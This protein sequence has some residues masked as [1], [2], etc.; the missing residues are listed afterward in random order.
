MGMT[1]EEYLATR[2]PCSVCDIDGNQDYCI[3]HLLSRHDNCLFYNAI[4]LNNDPYDNNDVL[5]LQNLRANIS[6]EQVLEYYRRSEPIVKLFKSQHG[7][8]KDFWSG[9]YD[10]FI[11]QILIEIRAARRD[12]VVALIFAMLDTL[13][14]ENFNN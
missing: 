7:N 6:G 4:I 5:L 10:R 2:Q 1:I 8:D 14:A 13:E 12:Q 11:K 9:I 3:T